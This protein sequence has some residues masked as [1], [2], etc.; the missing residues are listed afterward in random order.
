MEHYYSKHT[1]TQS[2]ENLI[3]ANL[4]GKEW[5]FVTDAGVFSKS[6]VDF[7]TRLLLE[8]VQVFREDRVLDLG[9]GYGVIGVVLACELS[10]G[11]V[12]M[13]DINERALSLACKNSQKYRLTNASFHSSDRFQGVPQQSFDHIITNP[14]IRAGKATIYKL[15]EEAT[16]YLSERGSLWIVIHKKHGAESAVKK[17]ENLYKSVEIVNKK[18]GYQIIRAY[19]G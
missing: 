16:E 5:S 17:L 3:H 11:Y 10:E 12:V 1:D 13:S 6:G 19:S 14:P 9:C 15:F 8:T 18:S 2:K 4:R 7:G